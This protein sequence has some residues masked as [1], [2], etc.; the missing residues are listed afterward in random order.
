MRENVRL[1][2]RLHTSV[3]PLNSTRIGQLIRD[4]R[5]E[6]SQMEAYHSAHRAAVDRAARI[7]AD[8]V[9]IPAKQ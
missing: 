9:R 1:R 8:A 3:S 4:G 6:L 2:F 5:E 7:T